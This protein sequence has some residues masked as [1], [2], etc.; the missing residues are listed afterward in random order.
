MFQETQTLKKFLILS[1]KKAFLIF[2]KTKYFLVFQET[3]NLKNVSYFR[4]HNFRIFRER[5]IQNPG[6]FRT[7]TRLEVEA[8]S[9]P[10]YI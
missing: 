8:Y 4:K 9:E 10:W 2:R 3:E 5:H 7:L 1:Q 6:I